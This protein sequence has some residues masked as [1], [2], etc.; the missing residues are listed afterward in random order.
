MSEP[1]PPP[2]RSVP[3]RASG[4]AIGF[5]VLAEIAE[6]AT[7]RV[8][9]CR[10]LAPHPRAGALVAVKRLHEHV[11]EDPTFVKQFLDE[12][13]IT[14]L[15]R[16][17]NVVE[18]AGWGTDAEGSFLA[19]ELVQGVSLARLM[20]TVF[21]T[22]EAFTERMVVYV[23][24]RVCYGLLA[25]HSLRAPDG[26]HL[27]LVHRDLTPSNVLVGFR[28]EVKIA[29]FGMAKAKR[30]LTQTLAGTR[31]GEPGYMA[32]EQASSDEIDGRADLFSLGVLLFELFTGRRPWVARTD[33]E[34]VPLM[35][36]APHADLRE[37]RPRIDKELVNVVHRCLERDPMV[38]WHSAHEIAVRLDEWL[39]VH[40]Y[41]D[42]NEEALA[43]FVRRNAMRQMRW[44]ERAVAGE[45]APQHVPRAPPRVPT[46]TEH[47]MPVP[48]LEPSASPHRP[49][50]PTARA[51]M[52]T[53]AVGRA[54]AVPRPADPRS[55]RAANAVQQLKKLAPP[56]EPRHVPAHRRTPTLDERD[57]LDSAPRVR[58]DAVQ[59]APSLLGDEVGEEVPTIVQKESP[60]IQEALRAE[61]AKQAASKAHAKRQHPQLPSLLDD[62]EDG[63]E[64]TTRV[65][66]G[67]GVKAA[68]RAEAPVPLLVDPEE[69]QTAPRELAP[70][71][72]DPAGPPPMRAIPPSPEVPK[73]PF[74]NPR[75]TQPLAPEAPRKA[76]HPK[77]EERPS[78]ITSRPVAQE[79]QAGTTSQD[80]VQVVDRRALGELFRDGG[81]AP[82]PPAVGALLDEES[83][84]A[85]ADRLA[86]EA[87]R[88]AEEARVAELRAE[89]K[90]AA[91]KMAAEASRIA[92]DALRILH[93]E[94]VA[95]ASRR[96][97]EARGIEHVTQSGK[98]PVAELATALREAASSA[99]PPAPSS[100]PSAPVS[101]AA[102]VFAGAA[103]A[104]APAI[105]H[106]LPAA[107]PIAMTP[108]P[109]AQVTRPLQVAPRPV[110]TAFD[111]D[112][113]RA[114][115][116]PTIFGLPRSAATGIAV[117]GALIVVV[118]VA[119]LA[120]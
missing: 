77:D 100:R 25:A 65:K 26:E 93:T 80:D 86:I 60:E 59:P 107:P 2:E 31:K 6:G 36:R 4:S 84:V 53:P 58:L 23:A 78:R 9:L 44:F 114:R 62:D 90:A 102:P 54:M 106:P 8:E 68:H 120:K 12:V 101:A 52:P 67:Q 18:V 61:L 117:A 118:L 119:L 43:R 30:R 69:V 51:P 71:A 46:Y 37:L 32:P 7:A 5:E 24:S 19:V 14:N 109:F 42:D 40:G 16:H 28:G 89:R 56:V 11:A 92:A 33:A 116:Q 47:S 49:V 103:A 105:S 45:L 21:E 38:R 48:G 20:K 17:P 10:V 57:T 3:A 15:L 96:I 99:V 29:D 75:I 115:L 22:G 112:D 83:I 66:P 41:Q 110:A 39:V 94:G 70:L 1:R 63:Q 97:E 108:A 95:A 50:A 74:A 55:L 73:R 34:T 76:A 35:M 91:A 85:E 104:A 81:K 88:S 82:D 72:P 98:I 13:R 27:N 87:V 64:A 79:P 111:A 113:F